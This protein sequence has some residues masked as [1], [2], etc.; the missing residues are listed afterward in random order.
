MTSPSNSLQ[1]A[2]YRELTTANPGVSVVAHPR[3]N[4]ALPFI[5]F[6]Q[7]E[8]SDA[9]VGH[10]LRAEIHTWSSTEGPHGC[11]AIQIAT[12]DILHATN[13]MENE[14]KYTCLREVSRRCFLDIDDETWHGVQVFRALANLA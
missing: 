9:P 11:D 12:R 5:H 8:A 7:F 10:E 6:G 3:V 1:K 2:L 13:P 14:W 4:E